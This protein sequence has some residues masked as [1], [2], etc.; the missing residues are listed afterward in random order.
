[1]EIITFNGER[2]GVTDRDHYVEI[3]YTKLSGEQ[4][5]FNHPN[6]DHEWVAA[7]NTPI[8]TIETD[9][10]DFKNLHANRVVYLTDEI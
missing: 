9:D 10:G 4:R 8:I 6:I 3:G 1:M 5:V 7:D 2:F